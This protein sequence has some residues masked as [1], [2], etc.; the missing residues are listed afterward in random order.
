MM[1]LGY[2][3]IWGD[4]IEHVS[5]LMLLRDL[6]VS[7]L[8]R[9]R[10][11]TVF[12]TAG[13]PSP[14]SAPAPQSF[15]MRQGNDSLPRAFASRLEGK[16]RYQC[17]VIGI[18]PGSTGVAVSYRSTAGVERLAADYAICAIPFSTLRHVA[19]DPLLSP[20]KMT[21][22]AE[23][24]NTS[25]CRVYV[26][27]ADTSWSMP[28][29]LGTSPVRIG[30]ANTDLSSQWFHNSTFV[31]PGTAGIIGAYAAGSRARAL[32]GLPDEMRHAIAVSEIAQ[33]FPGIGAPVGS[34]ITKVWDDDPWARGG[35]C[36]F[37][38]GD[39]QRFMP[40]LA[41][42]EGR[43]HF[44]GDHTSHSPGWMEGALESGHRA[45]A[46]VNAAP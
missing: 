17:P 27:V 44:A 25:V 46:E 20:P 3:D 4:G 36:W 30:T 37:R 6:A 10:L 16:I 8:P 42:P 39:M 28:S 2:F 21:A 1:R 29:E 15:T 9:V 13:V 18:E 40:Y 22:I 24:P 5:A 12:D 26:P 7:V 19:I 41:A 45:A 34:A 35:Y 14:S 43:I 38:P 23:L 31:Q 32:A 33:L 11:S